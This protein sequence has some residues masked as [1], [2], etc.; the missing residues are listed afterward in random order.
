MRK[1]SKKSRAQTEVQGNTGQEAQRG[2]GQDEEKVRSKRKQG[3]GKERL[4][5]NAEAIQDGK[6]SDRTTN[7]GQESEGPE[8][9]T[10]PSV[11]IDEDV[12]RAAR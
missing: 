6:A 2:G 8:R 12:S 5:T 9:G 11:V 4:G 3:S 7:M 10:A 1:Q